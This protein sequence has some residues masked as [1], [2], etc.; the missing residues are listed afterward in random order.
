MESIKRNWRKVPRIIRIPFVL[1]AGIAT[2]IAGIIMLVVPGPGLLA[3]FAGIA[4]I[5]TELPWVDRLKQWIERKFMIIYRYVKKR[6]NDHLGRHSVS[7]KLKK[8]L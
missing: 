7:H 5:A 1:L 8:R 2:I 6:W 4:I 3:I